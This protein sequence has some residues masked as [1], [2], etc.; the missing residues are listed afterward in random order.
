MSVAVSLDAL[1]DRVAEFG[2]VA[3]L[4]TVGGSGSPH[5]ASVTVAWE[6]D[7]LVMGAGRTSTANVA[8]G[9]TVTLLWPPPVADGDYSLLADGS[10]ELIRP[11]DDAGD[12]LVAFR[13]TKAVLH[14]T[15]RA[16][17]SG[18]TCVPL[19]TEAGAR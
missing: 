11:T 17:G 6:D 7:R 3:Y 19:G 14:R 2:P 10:A 18:P 1:R 4:V 16:A 9:G 12:L 13:P 8:A 5:I 15:A